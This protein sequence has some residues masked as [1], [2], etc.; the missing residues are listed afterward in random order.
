[1]IANYGRDQ[2]SI[3]TVVEDL[4]SAK[5]IRAVH[6]KN[7]LQEVMVDFWF[8]HFNVSIG[9]LYGR[10]SAGAYERDAIRPHALGR[11]RDLLGASAAHPA[12]LHYLDN[13]LSTV[14]REVGGVLRRGLNENY[15][16]E[17]MELH[18][19]GVDAGYTQ[20]DVFD[21]ARA[22]TGWGLVD[23]QTGR[24]Q[25]RLQ[26]HD[27]EAKSVFG[28][29]LPAGGGQDDGERVLDHLAGHPATALHVSRRLVQRFV[30][31]APPAGLVERCAQAY[32]RSDG[33]ISQVLL[34]IFGSGEFWAPE[35]FGSKPRT[36][37]EF[38]AAA[39]RALDA[40]VE[41]AR[42]VVQSLSAM[43]MPLYACVPPTGYSNSGAEWLNAS[44]QLA[45]MNFGLDLAAQSVAGVS[46]RLAAAAPGA[47]PDDPRAA[48]TAMA[49]EIF[50][51]RMSV[52][53]FEAAASVSAGATGGTP[54]SRVVGLLLAS[55]EFQAR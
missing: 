5:V 48:A 44:S 20:E 18:T 26:S 42:G 17:L 37:L 49:R 28:L 40:E 7:Q 27:R 30:S 11:F 43:G 23:G 14:S 4:T 22:F 46:V 52:S 41:R 50:G 6:A 10:F 8:N 15:G 13:Y 35:G 2:G 19:V 39:L 47:S 29:R 55:P 21:A 16:R 31:D 24:F 51:D 53:T 38:T 12:M 36:P 3:G 25:F 33:D 45:R 32:A 34:T 1:V 54:L 9:E